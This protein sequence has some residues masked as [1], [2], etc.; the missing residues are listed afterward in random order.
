MTDV[1]GEETEIIWDEAVIDASGH[2]VRHESKL[3]FEGYQNPESK[4]SHFRDD[5]SY[6]Y[7]NSAESVTTNTSDD[8][9]LKFGLNH[10]ISDDVL[11]TI[12]FTRLQFKQS[13]HGQRQ[14]AGRVL[15]GGAAGDAPERLMAVQRHEQRDFVHRPRLSVLRDR[16]DWPAYTD[17]LSTA[18]NLKADI[19][20]KK[21]QNHQFKT[22]IQFI[23]NDL[24][25]NSINFPGA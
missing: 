5:S 17:R 24:D 22:G 15:D 13:E 2:L 25:E 6:V 1:Y 21:W 4:F 20:S 11:Y 7:F 12:N 8:L 23:Y 10:N 9:N 14:E 18:Y 3:L 16:Y 19:T